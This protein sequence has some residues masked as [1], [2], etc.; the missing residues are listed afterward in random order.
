[1]T[2][3]IYHIASEKTWL[4]A[5]EFGEYLHPSLGRE[6]FIHCSTRG[7]VIDT[8]NRYFHGQSGLVMLVINPALAAAEIRYEAVGEEKFPH[9]YGSLNL[10][11]VV[12]VLPFH[13]D[14]QGH[15]QFPAQAS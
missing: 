10:D 8:A 2:E 6:G 3:P 1:M 13:P 7:Q 9:L 5:L 12:E 14:A 4:D 11:A 15:F